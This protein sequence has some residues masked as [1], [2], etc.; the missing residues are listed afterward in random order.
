M[1]FNTIRGRRVNLRRLRKSDALSLRQY[2]KDR[3]ISRYTSL[4]HPYR[5]QDAMSF[6]RQTHQKLRKGVAYELGIENKQRGRIIGMMSLFGIDKDNKNAE[7]G[8]WLGKRYWG[9]GIA[10]ESLQLILDFGFNEL[11]L[12]RIYA[13]VMHPN[14][15]SVKLLEKS[16]FSFEGRMRKHTFKN[17][18]WI[19]H[20]WYG[21]LKEEWKRYNSD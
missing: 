11:K 17:R 16:G 1:A 4:P 8:Y 15:S 19:D 10:K 3:E 7:V 5:I 6:I 9:T 14:I 21:L 20:L 13:K 18:R 12:R 2:A